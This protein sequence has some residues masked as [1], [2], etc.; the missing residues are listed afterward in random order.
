M[1]TVR[2]RKQA[3]LL[4]AA[5]IALA[6]PLSAAPLQSEIDEAQRRRALAFN[7]V[8]GD[9]SYQA[10][11]YWIENGEKTFPVEGVTVASTSIDMLKNVSAVGNDLKFDG[12]IAAPTLLIAE[13]TVSGKG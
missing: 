1:E 12:S 3:W 8:T 13:M 6:G 2:F 7:D 4:L 5:L 10:Q 9:Y 11:G